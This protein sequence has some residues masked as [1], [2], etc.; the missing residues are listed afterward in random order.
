MCGASRCAEAQ[1]S[2]YRTAVRHRSAAPLPTTKLSSGTTALAPFGPLPFALCPLS[3]CVKDSQF[4]F[5]CE[6]ARALMCLGYC[7]WDWL[8]VWASCE[9]ICGGERRK[10]PGFSGS[11]L[12][13]GGAG[14]CGSLNV[15]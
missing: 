15:V 3:T 14:L 4:S 6:V 5:L 1:G 13:D 8:Q 2:C 11:G 10:C 9:R 7:A 12:L